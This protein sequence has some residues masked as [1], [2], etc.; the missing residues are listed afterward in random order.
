MVRWH[1]RLLGTLALGIV[2][3]AILVAQATPATTPTVGASPLRSQLD[4][5]APHSTSIPTCRSAIPVKAGA[6][7]P[8]SPRYSEVDAIQYVTAHP[9]PRNHA[10]SAEHPTA[11][12]AR[13]MTIAQVSA[14]IQGGST[15]L[16]DD[17][18]VCYV[19]LQG[20]FIFPGPDGP[21]PTYHR[22]YEVFDAYSGNLLLFGA[23]P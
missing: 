18:L 21:G 9:M 14:L 12:V 4:R 13:F 16:P 2:I 19:E 5:P 15:G 7:T 11:V 6:S 20:N 23:R 10:G 1:A 22:G 3:A 8:S 17:A